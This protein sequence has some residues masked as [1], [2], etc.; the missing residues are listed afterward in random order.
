MN[1]EPKKDAYA[2][3]VSKISEALEKGVVPWHQPWLSGPPRSL[4]TGKGYRGFNQLLL[5]YCAREHDTPFWGTFRQIKELG[6]V[7]RK[8]ERSTPVSFWK[9]LDVDDPKEDGTTK[10]VMMCR[11]YSAFN[12]DQADWPDGEPRMVKEWRDKLT[13]DGPTDR[14]AAAEKILAEF[15][16]KPEFQNKGMVAYYSVTTDTV[17]VP[18]IENFSSADRYYQTVFHELTHA[19][20]HPKRLNRFPSDSKPST[21]SYSKEELVAELG[22]AFLCHEAGLDVQVEES[23]AYIESWMQKIKEDPRI[24][25]SAAG[26]AAKAADHILGRVPDA[27]QVEKELAPEVEKAQ[28]VVVPD[29]TVKPDPAPVAPEAA[30]PGIEPV[31]PSDVP[32]AKPDP[33]HQPDL[34][35]AQGVEEE[36]PTPDFSARLFAALDERGEPEQKSMCA[37]MPPP[38]AAPKRGG[39]RL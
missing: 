29:L 35:A 38:A 14:I 8:G 31:E 15:P 3:L 33:V 20:G 1:D 2:I 39:M 10:Q 12:A 16:G 32:V 26:Q 28:P 5:G 21:E 34:I 27:P 11:F 19:S 17:V 24:L 25:V 37:E 36:D 6:G 4:S 22:G 9:K 13:K 30:K 23:A 18:P 7:I